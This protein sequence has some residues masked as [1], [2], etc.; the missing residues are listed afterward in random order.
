MS[1]CDSATV[2]DKFSKHPIAPNELR[3]KWEDI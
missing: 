2:L 1:L 3:I